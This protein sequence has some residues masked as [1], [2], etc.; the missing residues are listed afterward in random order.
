[1]NASNH[2]TSSQGRRRR[3]ARIL[4]LLSDAGLLAWC[5]M[6]ALLPG[7]LLGPG[8]APILP[9]G[10]EG[11]TGGSWSELVASAPQTA[12]FITLLFRIFGAYGAAFSLVALLVAATAFARGERWAWWALLIGNTIGY[13]VPMTYDRIVHAV[14]P[15]EL[16]EYVGIAVVYLALAMTVPWGARAPAAQPS[17]A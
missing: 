17:G 10:Y 3:V 13:L 8:G 9:A 4:I 2:D 15:F 11:Y 1:M 5:A 6:A 14:G 12:E 7:K 16:M